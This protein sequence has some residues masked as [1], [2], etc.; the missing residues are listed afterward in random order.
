MRSKRANEDVSDD[1]ADS[2]DEDLRCYNWID[3]PTDP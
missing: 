3:D 2:G 1:P